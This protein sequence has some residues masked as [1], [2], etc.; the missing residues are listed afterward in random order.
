MAPKQTISFTALPN[1]VV[2]TGPTKK[3][4][5]SV[6]I[7]PRLADAQQIEADTGVVSQPRRLS[8]SL[9]SA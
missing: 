4:R 7:A 8:T 1:G 3:V 2:G 6:Y 9:T 5:L